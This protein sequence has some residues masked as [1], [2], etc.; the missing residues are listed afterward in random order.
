[1]I[2]LAE[3]DIR[4]VVYDCQCCN[5][6]YHPLVLTKKRRN[7]RNDLVKREIRRLKQDHRQKLSVSRQLLMV[8]Q[9]M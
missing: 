1:M 3:D 8:K 4:Y 6:K 7:R 2:H 9:D 5:E